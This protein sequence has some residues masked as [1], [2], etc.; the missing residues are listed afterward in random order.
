MSDPLYEKLTVILQDVFD[1]DELEATPELTADDVLGWD[2]F[3]NIRLIM[4]VEKSFSIKFTA[5]EVFGIRNIGELA[6]L[7]R[8][9]TR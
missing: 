3:A 5:A 9:R 4:T 2:S 6:E 1:D 7:I 8:S